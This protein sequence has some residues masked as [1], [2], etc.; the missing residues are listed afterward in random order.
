MRPKTICKPVLLGER[1]DRVGLL[2]MPTQSQ[3]HNKPAILLMNAGLVHRVGPQRLNVK[4][5]R[6][7][8]ELGFTSLRHDLAGFGDSPARADGLPF[9]T[10]AMKDSA[11]AMDYLARTRGTERF[12]P[13]G[14][15]SGADLSL[16]LAA[17]DSRVCGA[18]LIDSFAYTTWLHFV[19]GYAKRMMDR[20]S[21]I[22]L[23]TGESE[24]VQQLRKK[25][26]TKLGLEGAAAEEGAGATG[27]PEWIMPPKDEI[28]Q[29]VKRAIAQKTSLFFIFS[30]GPA[31]D[32][33][34]THF[35]LP[36][37][38]LQA[39]PLLSVQRFG[40]SDHTFTLAYNQSQ[41]VESIASWVQRIAV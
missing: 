17:Q 6:R 21:W 12:I 5:A 33:Y 25:I 41:L 24:L 30:G 36:Y 29:E 27:A 18:V 40:E 31:Y 38:R 1:Q 35:F 26:V 13:L 10:A 9:E 14:L 34:L 32:N 16:S 22:G 11:E 20:A 28:I 15:C 8:A 3:D 39:G 4:I 7:L 23:F 37:R 2:T 19:R